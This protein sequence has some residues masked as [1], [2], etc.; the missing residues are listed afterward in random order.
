MCK[1]PSV[2][3]PRAE[4]ITMPAGSVVVFA[5][6]L[7]HRGG[8][9]TSSGKR[10]GITPQYCQPWMRQIENMVL[11]VPPEAAGQYSERIQELL[12][13]DLMEPSFV[14]YVGP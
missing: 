11:A 3:D 9:N 8:A 7:Y 14:G 1:T 13:Y 10:L 5:G 2:D 6:T 4:K 12:G